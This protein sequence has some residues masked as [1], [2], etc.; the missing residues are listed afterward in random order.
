VK[1]K[2][3]SLPSSASPKTATGK[4]AKEASKPAPAVVTHKPIPDSKPPNTTPAQPAPPP[5]ADGRDS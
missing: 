3:L 1:S 2:T 5:P 4:S